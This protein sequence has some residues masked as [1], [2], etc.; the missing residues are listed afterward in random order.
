META[1]DIIGYLGVIL[2]LWGICMVSG[3]GIVKLWKRRDQ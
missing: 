3:H 1:I 2:V